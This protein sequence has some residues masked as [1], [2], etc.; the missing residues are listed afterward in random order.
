MSSDILV[1]PLRLLVVK[2]GLTCSCWLVKQQH[3]SNS[4]QLC[5]QFLTLLGLTVQDTIARMC[6]LSEFQNMSRLTKQ[7]WNV[8]APAL[9][10]SPVTS[11]C[12]TTAGRGGGIGLYQGMKRRV[13]RWLMPAERLRRLNQNISVC[14]RPVLA[15]TLEIPHVMDL[16]A[17]AELQ[18]SHFEQMLRN[19][20]HFCC[21]QT[22]QEHKLP[23]GGLCNITH[24]H[25]RLLLCFFAGGK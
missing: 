24:L 15:K 11:D 2:P 13:R 4:E 5:R 6:L 14:Q 12:S 16:L 23:L 7:L 1:F 18:K 10:V 17:E 25:P 19:H 8:H 22:D 21:Q 20:S 9:V 3:A